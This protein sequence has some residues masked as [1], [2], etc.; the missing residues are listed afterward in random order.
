MLQEILRSTGILVRDIARIGVS[1]V[2]AVLEVPRISST[3]VATAPV[4]K[5]APV[6]SS[7]TPRERAAILAH[8]TTSHNCPYG[9]SWKAER[10]RFVGHNRAACLSETEHIDASQTNY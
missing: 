5:T 7:L 10:H 8:L 2:G 9:P 4:Q 3:A 6:H 1:I